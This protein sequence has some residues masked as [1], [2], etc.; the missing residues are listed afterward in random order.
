MSC[1]EN[2]GMN[3]D[4]SKVVLIDQQEVIREKKLAELIKNSPK[5]E[6]MVEIQVSPTAKIYRPKG[7]DVEKAKAE[8]YKRY[9]KTSII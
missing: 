8:F 3:R 4:M 9:P 7:T 6:K 2:M 1:K 5:T